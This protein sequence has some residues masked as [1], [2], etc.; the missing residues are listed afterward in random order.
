METFSKCSSYVYLW[1]CGLKY[2]HGMN[3]QKWNL[4]VSALCS[5][6]MLQSNLPNMDT[7]GKEPGVHITGVSVAVQCPEYRHQRDRAKW[8]HYRQRCL[9][10]SQTTSIRTPK[11][12]NQVSSLQ[13]CLYSSQTSIIQTPEGQ[14]LVATLQTEVSVLQS[15]HFNKDTKGT[16]PSVLITKVFV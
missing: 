12:Q 15:N 14:S 13:R 7:S 11:G 10:Y 1:S 5:G 6:M 9:Y 4:L 16:E 3:I 2:S 8:P